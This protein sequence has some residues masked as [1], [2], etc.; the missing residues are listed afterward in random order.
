MPINTQNLISRL[1]PMPK[2]DLSGFFD[3]GQTAQQRQQLE[4][5]RAAL[6][7]TKRHNQ[8]QERIQGAQEQ[9]ASQA[10][11]AARQAAIATAQREADTKTLELKRQAG[12]KFGETLFGKGDVQGAHAMV[13]Y[14]TQLGMVVDLDGEE[15]GLPKYSIY[16]SPE[17]AANGRRLD[18][19]KEENPNPYL[20]P[21]E[22][23]APNPN[24][25]DMPAMH[26]R[27]LQQLNPYMAGAVAARPADYQASAEQTA[28]AV[29]GL[30]LPLSESIKQ[31]QESQQAPDQLIRADINAS[32]QAGDQGARLAETKALHAQGRIKEG[33]DLAE[34]AGKEVNVKD[35]WERRRTVALAR[36][37]LTNRGPGSELDDYMAGAGISRMM[38]ERGSTTEQDVARVLGNKAASFLD[39]IWGGAYRAAMGGLTEDQKRG[40]L[41][42]LAKSQGEDDRRV[43]DFLDNLDEQANKPDTDPEARKGIEAYRTLHIPRDLRE[44]WQKRKAAKEPGQKTSEAKPFNMEA[45]SKAEFGVGENQDFQTALDSAADENGVDAEK[46]RPLMRKESGGDPAAANPQSSARGMIQMIDSVAKGYTNPRTGQKFKDSDE[47]AELSAVEQAPIVAQYFKDKGV[48][49]DSPAEDY[50]LAVAAPGFIGKPRETVVYPKD[51]DAWKVN[52]P[53]RPAGGGDITVGSILDFYGVKPAA[54]DPQARL[55][56]LRK[57]KAEL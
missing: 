34:A 27:V 9:H 14:M 29:R 38:G 39:Q 55:A 33:S 36:S 51:S 37:V 30:G 35:V 2:L 53:W 31:F 20:A 56:E 18:T 44:E 45:D 11:E 22:A 46:I 24:K 13:P 49:K 7:E 28:G 16:M 8:E 41:G 5:T 57:K 12:L 42:I 32:A 47:L 1:S 23:E 52:A 50:A 19:L 21:G 26:E 6:E 43:F 4:Q 10:A 54:V 48:T 25:F 3:D 15:H 40:L 17:D